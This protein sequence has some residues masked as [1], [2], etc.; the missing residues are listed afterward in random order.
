MKPSSSGRTS[1]ANNDG[2]SIYTTDVPQTI[3]ASISAATF[4]NRDLERNDEVY[5]GRI[6][7]EEVTDSMPSAESNFKKLIKNHKLKCCFVFTVLIV[8]AI[9]KVT[10]A[11]VEVL[12]ATSTAEHQ[13]TVDSDRTA[14]LNRTALN[15]LLK[16]LKVPRTPARAET[17]NFL[18]TVSMALR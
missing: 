10:V 9:L 16:L 8:L 3:Q 7:E 17:E 6:M 11:E 18:S 4:N 15:A 5:E 1:K 13:I 2:M 12:N 14:T